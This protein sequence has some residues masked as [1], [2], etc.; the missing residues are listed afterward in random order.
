VSKF[1]EKA[2]KKSPFFISG[3][4]GFV[5]FIANIDLTG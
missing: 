2:G 3:R 1:D 5:D 4:Q